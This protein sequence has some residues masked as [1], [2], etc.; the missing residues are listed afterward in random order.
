M[1]MW[2]QWYKPPG[3]ART[4]PKVGIARR[5]ISHA[6]DRLEIPAQDV[7]SSRRNKRLIYARSMVAV[8]LKERGW[9]YPRIGAA[10]GGRDHTTIIHSVERAETYLAMHP[11]LAG[12][13]TSMRFLSGVAA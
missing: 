3:Y 8:V 5:L 4:M 6:A 2:P 11:P 10:L 9:S 13:L 7:V 12:I 1:S